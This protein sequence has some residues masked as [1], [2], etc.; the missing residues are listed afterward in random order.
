[1]IFV[2]PT[3]S[4][5]IAR[6][7]ERASSAE[8]T[9]AETAAALSGKHPLGYRHDHHEVVLG[10]GAE[11]FDR[12]VQGLQ[13]WTTHRVPGI[14]V[15]PEGTEVR[16]GATVVVTIGTPLSAIAAPC[17][18]ID[19]VDEP[20]RWGFAYGTLPGHP[21]EGEEAFIA[22]ISDDGTVAFAITAFS[23]PASSL[24]RISGPVARAVQRRVTL[25]YIRSM[26]HFVDDRVPR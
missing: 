1:M 24:M 12:A 9:Y 11:T 14:R 23:R 10:R 15:L 20:G 5:S 4:E 17:R 16:P 8:P 2:R 25:G 26:Q 22:S 18:V 13:M 19:I 7:V 21:E 3:D 6:L